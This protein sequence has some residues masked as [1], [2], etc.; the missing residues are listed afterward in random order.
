MT[1]EYFKIN[2]NYTLYF[3]LLIVDNSLILNE[4]IEGIKKRII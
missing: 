3:K 4:K 2:G 1:F